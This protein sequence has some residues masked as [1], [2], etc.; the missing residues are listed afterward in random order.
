MR[1]GEK[2]KRGA[3][4]GKNCESANVYGKITFSG[5]GTL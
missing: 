4:R 3:K 2:L 5:G 1:G